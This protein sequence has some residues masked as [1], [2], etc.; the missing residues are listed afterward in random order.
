MF[1]KWLFWKYLRNLI[2]IVSKMQIDVIELSYNS[3]TEYNLENTVCI[4][5]LQECLM[6]N[7][8]VLTTLKC[9][10]AQSNIPFMFGVTHRTNCKLR[11]SSYAQ[12]TQVDVNGREQEV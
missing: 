2:L 1:Q 5:S 10:M 7:F 4:I 12:I 8:E 6:Y 9:E 3:S 11:D